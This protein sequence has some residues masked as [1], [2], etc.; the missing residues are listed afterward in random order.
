MKERTV[1]TKIHRQCENH[2][3]A[4]GKHWVSRFYMKSRNKCFIQVRIL[5][6][7]ESGEWKK[8]L[9]IN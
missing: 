9:K 3:F 1:R 8:F 7:N 6:I 4:N 5:S 2:W